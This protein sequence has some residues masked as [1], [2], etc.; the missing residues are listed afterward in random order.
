MSFKRS[1]A[2]QALVEFAVYLPVLLLILVGI[3]DL[4]IEMIQVMMVQEA[5]T[6]GANFGSAP[7]NQ[8]NDSGMAAWAQQAAAGVNL[9]STP[10]ASTFYT[11]TPGGAQVTS[12]TTCPGGGG[13][14]EYVQ[15]TTKST[16]A[17]IFGLK[18]L[19]STTVTGSAIYRVAWKTQ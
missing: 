6:E 16:F 15:L 14:M 2:G 4:G 3:S 1:E 11:C 10:V 7:G 5:A 8:L 17:P 19:V 18:G 13:P 12:S 9:S